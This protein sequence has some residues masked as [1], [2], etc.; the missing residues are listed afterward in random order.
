LAATL[1]FKYPLVGDFRE[2]EIK[3]AMIY[4][5]VTSET[6]LCID[7]KDITNKRFFDASKRVAFVFLRSKIYK[8]V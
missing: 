7:K 6:F 2:K 3:E 4:K 5:L 1:D 8:N